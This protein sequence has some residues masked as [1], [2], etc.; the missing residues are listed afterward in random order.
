[1]N[2]EDHYFILDDATMTGTPA[3]WARESVACFDKYEANL[4][5]GEVNQGGDLVE[6]NLR[7][8]RPLIPYK[9]VRA[10][11]NKAIRAEPVATACEK[12]RLHFV[13]ELPELENELTSWAPASGEPSPDRMDAMVWA[14][15]ELMGGGKRIG[16]WG[17]VD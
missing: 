14:V 8:V 3:A 5:V 2:G 4:I 12:G 9:A 7:T 17:H 13:G 15:T 11:R 1:M 6:A 10:T 16:S